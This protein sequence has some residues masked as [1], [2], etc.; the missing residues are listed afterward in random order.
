MIRLRQAGPFIDHRAVNL[1]EAGPGADALPGIFGAGDAAH[2]DQRNGAAGRL[3]ERAQRVQR[4]RGERLAG[5]AARFPRQRRAQASGPRD[6]GV[7]DDQR[8][9]PLVER[10]AADRINVGMLEI[11]RQLEEDRLVGARAAITASSRA[12]RAPSSCRRAGPACWAS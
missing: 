1:D 10:D 3:A 7:R 9:E 12:L 8:I 5:Q 11:G 6:R 2:A 4:Q